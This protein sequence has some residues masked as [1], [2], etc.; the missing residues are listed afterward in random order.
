MIFF[1]TT[2]NAT[3]RLLEVQP[4]KHVYVFTRVSANGWYVRLRLPQV[5]FYVLKSCEK[6]PNV[7]RNVFFFSKSCF[8]MCTL[9]FYLKLLQYSAAYTPHD[10]RV[11]ILLKSFYEAFATVGSFFGVFGE[12]VLLYRI[13]CF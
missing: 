10:Y 12:L 11:F 6:L 8:V 4:W 13:M 1:V 7:H 5:L 3:A 9:Q 2:I